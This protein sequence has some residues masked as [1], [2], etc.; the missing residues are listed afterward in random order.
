M[1]PFSATYIMKP[2]WLLWE[3]S[4]GFHRQLSMLARYS[5]NPCWETSHGNLLGERSTY[6][7]WWHPCFRIA[8]VAAAWGKEG[9]HEP[10]LWRVVQLII[11]L[12][13][14]LEPFWSRNTWVLCF[15]STA[16]TTDERH[17]GVPR[18]DMH[19][20]VVPLH[21]ATA[22]KNACEGFAAIQCM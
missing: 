6:L 15:W 12:T 11:L 14:M 9:F 22:R 2:I 13:W 4:E 21:G 19:K 5:N 3:W 10:R 16:S 17:R 7:H 1:E 20:T 18:T 8:P